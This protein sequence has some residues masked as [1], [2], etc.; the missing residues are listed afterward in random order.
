MAPFLLTLTD[1]FT[2][3]LFFDDRLLELGFEEPSGGE[4]S[5]VEPSGVELSWVE[6]SGVGTTGVDSSGAAVVEFGLLSD[7][8]AGSSMFDADPHHSQFQLPSLGALVVLDF[9]LKKEEQNEFLFLM[10]PPLRKI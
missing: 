2:C 9:S 4:P 5:G 10:I 1:F 6:P 7:F 8:V 3:E